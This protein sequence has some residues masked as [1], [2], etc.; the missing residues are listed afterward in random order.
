MSA[1][2]LKVKIE[3]GA[4]LKEL[5]PTVPSDVQDTLGDQKIFRYRF[6]QQSGKTTTATKRVQEK[7][8]EAEGDDA[9]MLAKYV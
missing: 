6:L 1:A 3:C 8:V 9:P 5:D 7:R 4:V 2:E